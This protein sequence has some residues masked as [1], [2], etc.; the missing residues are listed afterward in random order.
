[1]RGRGGKHAAERLETDALRDGLAS[2]RGGHAKSEES[3]R[4]TLLGKRT[5]MVCTYTRGRYIIV[6]GGLSFSLLLPRCANLAV[7]QLVIPLSNHRRDGEL[8]YGYDT[9]EYLSAVGL[10]LQQ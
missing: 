5:T 6:S 4:G 7:D 3:V 2:V 10:S 8:D 1:M 9:T